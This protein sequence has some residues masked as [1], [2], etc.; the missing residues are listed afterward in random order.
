MI[1]KTLKEI[2]AEQFNVDEDGITAETSFE[3][4]LGADSVDILEVSLALEEA[5]DIEEMGEEDLSGIK[6][7]G[8]LLRLLQDRLEDN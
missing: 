3:H 2:L 6:T 8:D 1:F 5:F 7:V 4:D